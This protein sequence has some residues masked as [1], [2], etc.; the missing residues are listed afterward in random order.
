MDCQA[1]MGGYADAESVSRVCR[2]DAR[3]VPLRSERGLH[4]GR[5]GAQCLQDALETSA[6]TYKAVMNAAQDL[7]RMGKMT[8]EQ[9]NQ[10]KDYAVVYFDSYQ[11]AVAALVKYVEVTQGVK[12]PGAEAEEPKP[13]AAE[14][15]Q[16]L[17]DMLSGCTTTLNDLLV[18]VQEQDVDVAKAKRDYAEEYENAY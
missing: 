8:D 10:V 6:E 13:S 17:G 14:Q 5:S 3:R 2:I 18:K 1:R 4:Q 12:S 16:K 9:W 15:E 11:T 7:H